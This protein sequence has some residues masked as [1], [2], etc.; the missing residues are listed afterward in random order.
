MESILK[1]KEFNTNWDV[2]NA[3]IEW[4][5]WL[6]TFENYTAFYKAKNE[7][8]FSA[9]TNLLSPNIYQY[10]SEIKSYSDAI[11]ALN[12]IYV[13]R[14]NPIFSRHKLY[15]RKQRP[16]ET[17][18]QYIKE[19]TLLTKNCNFRKVS[20]LEYEEEIVRDTFI[21]GITSNVIR[22]RL[23]EKQDLRLS[24][25]IQIALTIE[26]AN[27]NTLLY[28]PLKEPVINAIET[29]DSENDQQIAAAKKINNRKLCYFCGK[30]F[31]HNRNNCPAR[32]ATC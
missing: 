17:I 10:I 31:D 12:K 22:Q 4:T 21:S 27:N 13:K 18:N 1:P 26:E 20:A 3:E 5:H 24:E 23:L 7:E 30:N 15:S 25:A 6:K 11:E 29:K 19:L 9:L 16:E 8:K 28:Q 32:N 2:D 14:H